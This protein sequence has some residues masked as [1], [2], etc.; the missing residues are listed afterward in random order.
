MTYTGNLIAFD[1]AFVLDIGDGTQ[2]IVALDTRYHDKI[3]SATP[4]PIRLARYLEI[5]KRSGVFG[6]RA[7]E[8]V[9]GTKLTVMWLEHLLVLSMLQDPSGM[10][11]WGRYV[12]VYPAGNVDFAEA[13]AEYRDLLV[14]QSTFSSITMEE[15]LAANVL[16]SKTKAALRARYLPS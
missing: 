12:V 2:G 11:T 14:D 16:P 13:C 7:I 3:R 5:T 6:P 4:K 9:N 15:L 8:M 10:W 1:A